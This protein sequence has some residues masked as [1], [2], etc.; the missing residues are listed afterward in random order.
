MKEVSQVHRR[1]IH[2]SI[3]GL[4]TWTAMWKKIKLDPFFTWY[5]EIH[6]KWIRDLNKKNQALQLL[7][8]FLCNLCNEKTF[9]ELKSEKRSTNLIT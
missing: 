4:N 1:K 5:T 9:L 3:E 6:S 2:V 7:E 8:E